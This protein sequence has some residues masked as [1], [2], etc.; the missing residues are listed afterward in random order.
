MNTIRQAIAH[1]QDCT[2]KLH[3]AREI[4][5][6]LVVAILE[7]I[8]HPSAKQYQIIDCGIHNDNLYII[9]DYFAHGCNYG[10]TIT[11]PT[12]VIDAEDHL[13]AADKYLKQQKLEQKQRQLQKYEGEIE[14]LNM[15][16]AEIKKSL[17]ET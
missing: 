2:T 7:K 3:D 17:D 9:Y 12:W 8:G 13:V 1:I 6:T 14:S 4:L 15:A 11:I 16:I 10:D 5:E